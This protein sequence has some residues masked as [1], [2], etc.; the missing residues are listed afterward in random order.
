MRISTLVLLCLTAACGQS[1]VGAGT[2]PGCVAD[3]SRCEVE[4]ALEV[5][6]CTADGAWTVLDCALGKACSRAVGRCMDPCKPGE[7]RCEVGGATF[8]LTCDG[9]GV[10]A[11]EPCVSGRT[12][13]LT[14][15]ACAEPCKPAARRCVA[16]LPAQV[17][18]CGANGVWSTATCGDED[19]CSPATAACVAATC[20]PGQMRCEGAG[21][22]GARGL[23]APHRM[24]FVAHDCPAGT[25]CVAEPNGATCRKVVCDPSKTG[26]SIDLAAVVTC[27]PDG[28]AFK[29][30][31]CGI[32]ET[33]EA[34]A[35]VPATVPLGGVLQRYPPSTEQ[36]L[37]LDAGRYALA[38]VSLQVG[39]ATDIDFPVSVTGKVLSPPPPDPVPPPPPSAE[40]PP[41]FRCATP[42]LLLQAPA[43]G[44]P[45]RPVPAKAVTT[46]KPGDERLFHVA[47][48]KGYSSTVSRNGLLRKTTPSANFWEDI[49]QSAPGAY[50][51]EGILSELAYRVEVGVIP[52]NTAIFGELTDLDGNGRIDVFV[53]SA[54]ASGVTAF[55]SPATLFPA[56]YFAAVDTGEIVYVS[57]QATKGPDAPAVLARVLAHE[58]QH[59]IYIGRRIA[60][61]DGAP[62]EVVFGQ[63]GD[64]FATEGMAQVAA[65]WSGHKSSTEAVLA[66]AY[67]AE[68][69]AVDLF[70]TSYGQAVDKGVGYS[71][72]LL[73][74]EYLF[75]QAGA[76]AFA[77]QGGVQDQG[78]RAFV[79]QF[80]N[81]QMGPGRLAA[82]DG[83]NF[84]QVYVDLGTALLL[85]SLPATAL[86]NAT[87]AQPRFHFRP[88]AT[89]AAFD[90]D[91]GV[92]LEIKSKP[93]VRRTPWDERSTFLRLG[94]MAFLDLA[95]GAG[96]A[97]VVATAPNV[98]LV[99]VQYVEQ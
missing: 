97:E 37:H 36:P 11:N 4:G 73:V 58:V 24:G 89:D 81:G 66:L 31:P 26:C 50:L 5:L 95:V 23:C 49:T 29:S 7:A 6:S 14:S 2:E 52:R 94:G 43:V 91:I 76:V 84:G 90:G 74:Q 9:A 51:P 28:T 46:P 1:T 80:T 45:L 56:N 85:A 39:S 69:S 13:D 48:A 30:Q 54:V 53:T 32:A 16:G 38:V 77:G 79:D 93:L 71:H 22:S 62:T 42:F 78:G 47:S 55:V 21:A 44:P 27:E 17:E 35:C 33:C 59:L 72:A 61:Y 65:S 92:A 86:S 19:V 75:E 99:L 67:P 57:P 82:M 12:C 83:R 3:Q 40:V 41:G 8:R 18:T 88:V 87:A 10:W 70:A 60:L 20:A 64:V 68:M 15:G 96:G 34:G 25:A 63:L 98:A